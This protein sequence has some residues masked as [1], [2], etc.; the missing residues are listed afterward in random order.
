MTSLIQKH[1]QKIDQLAK[2]SGITYLA[3]FGSHARGDERPDSDVDLLV[4]YKKS[5]SFSDLFETQEKLEKILNKKVDLITKNGIN[6]Y[7]KP[8]ILKDLIPIYE[9]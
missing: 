4:E 2:E 3:V 9:E 6:K 5:A 7:F 1:R 8:Y